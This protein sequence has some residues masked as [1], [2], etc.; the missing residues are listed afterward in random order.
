MAAKFAE[1]GPLLL[2]REHQMFLNFV[3]L[4]DAWRNMYNETTL[5]ILRHGIIVGVAL[6]PIS[7]I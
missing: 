5:H 2:Q 4:A 6:I 1:V 7:G 3:P